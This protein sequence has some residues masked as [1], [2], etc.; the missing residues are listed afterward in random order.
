MKYYTHPSTKFQL[1][2]SK[3]AQVRR[4]RANLKKNWTPQ[5]T[6]TKFKTKG[7]W[8]IFYICLQ[9]KDGRLNFTKI[10]A[11]ADNFQKIQNPIK[12]QIGHKF[13]W[14]SSRFKG[15]DCFTAV[16]NF[17][18]ISQAVY[19]HLKITFLDYS[20]NSDTNIPKKKFMKT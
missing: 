4:F 16:P 6:L 1:D 20:E 13:A 14:K 10:R 19:E 3:F 8:L 5:S 17:N 7:P 9:F 15:R 18:S 2:N 11:T 12:F